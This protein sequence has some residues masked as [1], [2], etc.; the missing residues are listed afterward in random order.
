MN[1]SV[2]VDKLHFTIPSTYSLDEIVNGLP[3]WNTQ[4]LFPGITA[5]MFEESSPENR[6][7]SWYRK[8][9]YLRSELG[10]VLVGIHMD[11]V[12][13]Y[14]K[15]NMVQINGLAFSESALNPLRKIDLQYLAQRITDLEG[16]I[17]AVDTFL[18]VISPAVPFAEIARQ[19]LAP[20]LF[21]VGS[22][23]N[24]ASLRAF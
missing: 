1:V 17:T 12:S 4:P 23:P 19:S 6:K 18:D 14:G 7:R 24:G 20:S 13:K 21:R 3:G 10:A 11:S 5:D 16:K 22:S 9:F 15:R 8:H 2:G